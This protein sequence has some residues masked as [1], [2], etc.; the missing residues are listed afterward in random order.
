MAQGTEKR[1]MIENSYNDRVSL[2]GDSCI[3]PVSNA[4]NMKHNRNSKRDE[5]KIENKK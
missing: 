1:G 4:P 3:I 2:L 5:E